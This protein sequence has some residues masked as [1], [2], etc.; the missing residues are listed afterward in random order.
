MLRFA[1]ICTLAVMTAACAQ[2]QAPTPPPARIDS[3]LLQGAVE[4]LE[5]EPTIAYK[6]VPYAAPPV[7]PL[8]WK[9]PQPPAPWTGARSATAFGPVCPQAAGRGVPAGAAQSED[10]LTLNIWAPVHAA[11]PLP[12]MVWIHGGGDDAGTA[13]QPQ[14]DGAVFARD[15][16]VFVSVDYR[17]GA[18]GWFAHPA[19]T[20]RPRRVRRS[21]TTA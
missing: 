17:L 19:L 12:V 7:G 9:P 11:G 2:A 15:D 18:L 3:G 5:G 6:G 1:L 10:C 16:V 13:S 21:P 8:R 4:T 20:R 14:F